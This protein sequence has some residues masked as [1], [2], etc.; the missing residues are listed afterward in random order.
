MGAFLHRLGR[1]AVRRRWSVISFWLVVLV[2]AGV[3]AA[4]FS[5][6]KSSAFKIPGAESQQAIDLLDEKFPGTGGATARIVIAAPDGH[7][8]T[9]AGYQAA[10]E[11]ALAEVARAPEVVG[12][13]PWNKAT[14][15]DNGK[16]AF[17][18]ISYSVSVDEVSDQ[19]K[20]ALEKIAD[21]VRAVGL[22]VDFS[23]GVITSSGGAS[24]SELY[25]LI[26]AFIVLGI[27]FGGLVAAGLPML[28]ALIGVAL[29]LLGIEALS[30]V[31]SLS[32]S[33]PTLALMLGLAVGIDYALFLLTRHRQNLAEGMA[34]DDSI[35]LATATA[36]GAVTFAGLTVVI[37]LSGLAVVG[38]P[39]LTIMGLAAAGTVAIVVLIAL[40]LVPA[41]LAVLGPRVNAGRIR[42]L[43]RRTARAAAAGRQ[44]FGRRWAGLVTARPWLTVLACL[45]V[46]GVLAI[47][48]AGMKLGLPDD[49]SKPTS[50]TERRAYDLLTDGFGPGFNGP[51][52]LVIST[53]GSTGAKAAAT[54]GAERLRT[55]DD[56][57]AVGTPT[58]NKAGDVAILTVTPDSGPS[59]QDTKD[60]VKTIRTAAHRV[61]KEQGV[62]AYVTGTTAS[63]IDVSDKLS[64][65]LPLFLA[66]IV[67]LALV[68]LT[69]VF[70][71]LLVPVKAVLGFLLSIGASLGVTVFVFQEGHLGSL[72]GVES[73]GPIVSFLPVL[74]IGILFGLAMDYEMFLVSRVREHYVHHRDPS[75]AI[76]A[77]MAA[78]ARVITAA[79]LIMIAVFGSFI[80][81]DDA[82]I[83]SVGLA[84]AIGVAVD[85]F[86]VRMTLVPAILKLSGHVSWALPKALDR[87]VPDLD[88]EGSHLTAAHQATAGSNGVH[89]DSEVLSGAV[90][91]PADRAELTEQHS[92]SGRH[93]GSG[94]RR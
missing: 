57:A 43:Q 23:G 81:G 86:V 72:F 38:I 8:V 41:L 24:S 49:S 17:S 46:A 50:T 11:K 85:A 34:I 13:T 58:A 92:S 56:I 12:V 15:S 62:A 21:Q 88:L 83:K 5:G 31:I 69:I 67:G 27:T 68:L 54:T 45:V 73:T 30:G 48:L 6:P 18:D 52:T 71:S 94:R 55:A 4:A 61:E 37:A 47:P 29:G 32:D 14:V 33:A 76:T 60:L 59:S 91:R 20:D 82:V 87:I 78:T 26:I 35:A 16:V 28:I 63:N 36:G 90:P 51:L 9:E 66:L 22:Q 1:F 75:N 77:G 70:R 19:A 79:A 25:G 39:F 64:G 3:C 44:P 2:I 89:T 84:L 74:L 10:A 7:R 93:S 65:A 53:P 42:P 80:F 40:T